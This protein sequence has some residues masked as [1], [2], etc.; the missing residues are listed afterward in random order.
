MKTLKKFFV[1][2]DNKGSQTERVI[3]TF[4]DQE[5][6]T[7]RVTEKEINTT[8]E[9]ISKN[10][11]FENINLNICEKNTK[12][13]LFFYLN[14]DL[15]KMEYLLK[16]GLNP[17]CID[18]HFNTKY[19]RE[20]EKPFQILKLLHSYGMDISWKNSI[21]SYI[22]R[23]FILKNKKDEEELTNIQIYLLNNDCSFIEKH[24]KNVDKENINNVSNDILANLTPSAFNY[25]IKEKKYNLFNHEVDYNG[26]KLLYSIIYFS[27]IY[28]C[29]Y[30]DYRLFKELMNIIP[31]EALN[32]INKNG[33]TVLWFEYE[34]INRFRILVN[35]GVDI[36]IRNKKGKNILE[37]TIDE[38]FK[39]KISE[40]FK[41]VKSLKE[42][43]LLKEQFLKEYNS[44]GKILKRI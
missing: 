3:L 27:N 15:N 29:N 8:I 6:Q 21:M 39:I 17:N 2:L 43:N 40:V 16:K 36:E 18:F 12:R 9:L 41:E 4:D 23:D 38:E 42:N 33:E 28:K 10:N 19:L 7:K 37:E 1:N 13:H 31:N 14:N 24:I 22:S 44:I 34:D 30:D 26:N 35:S 11:N 25:L 20:S 32:S 5:E